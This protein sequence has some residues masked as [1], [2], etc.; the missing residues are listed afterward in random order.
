MKI[1]LAADGSE[2][3]LRAARHVAA[4]GDYLAEPPTVLLLN[5]QPPVASGLVRRF[6]SQEALDGYYR[7]EA[8]GALEPVEAVLAQGGV[9][10][11][12]H[13]VVGDVAA[14]IAEFAASHDCEQIVM[15]TRGL[16]GVKGALL[17]SVAS[18]VLHLADRPVL[19]VK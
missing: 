4:M 2:H 5:V 19:L 3:A 12:S 17:G 13:V 11:E 8:R 15:G 14:T 6:L 18:E 16:G 9:V 10:A 7:D 1:L